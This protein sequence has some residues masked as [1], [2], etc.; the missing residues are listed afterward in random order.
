VALA[1]SPSPAEKKQFRKT[2]RVPEGTIII[3]KAYK[4]PTRGSRIST[5]CSTP[6]LYICSINYY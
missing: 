1:A 4:L 5:I 3:G 2:F 6:V